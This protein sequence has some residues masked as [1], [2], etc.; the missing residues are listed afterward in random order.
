LKA[1]AVPFGQLL[2]L[3]TLDQTLQ[4]VYKVPKLSQDFS[5]PSILE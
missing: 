5:Q 1:E 3:K 4:T 2:L